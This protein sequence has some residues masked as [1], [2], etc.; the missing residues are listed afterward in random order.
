[1][2]KYKLIFFHVKR[3]SMSNVYISA[4]ELRDLI[5]NLT[6]TELELYSVL[7]ESVLKNVTPDYFDSNNLA[8]E[9]KLSVSS[10]KNAKTG[11]KQKGYALINKFKDDQNKDCLRIIVGKEQVEL[12][13]L[14]LTVEITDTKFYNEMV[15]HYD[16]F[17][18]TY[19]KQQREEIIKQIN[20]EYKNK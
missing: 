16:L 3:K 13:N 12:Y 18:P 15:K 8:K 9:L 1:M 2:F 5:K 14:G 11:L 4:T 6:S 17:N 19:T 10:I 7:H 20:E